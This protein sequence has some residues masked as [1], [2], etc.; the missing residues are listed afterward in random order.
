[1][2]GVGDRDAPSSWLRSVT[3][4]PS[5]VAGSLSEGDSTFLFLLHDR[6]SQRTAFSIER[7]AL[8][9]AGD[10]T[11]VADCSTAVAACGSGAAV[12]AVAV[13]AADAATVAGAALAARRGCCNSRGVKAGG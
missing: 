9:R 8:E 5:G 4:P 11:V 7:T 6:V 1:M 12:A 3:L 10:A 2:G 13:A